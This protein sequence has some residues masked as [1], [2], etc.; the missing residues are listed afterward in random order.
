MSIGQTESLFEAAFALKAEAL[1]E[2]DRM[3]QPLPNHQL[4]TF[5]LRRERRGG[6]R[7]K[8]KKIA[9]DTA[10]LKLRIDGDRQ[11]PE[12]VLKLRGWH[13]ISLDHGD[14]PL[15]FPC[16]QCN[17]SAKRVSQSRFCPDKIHLVGKASKAT[18]G[19]AHENE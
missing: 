2:P 10:A 8:F 5:N 3:G 16:A 17:T 14:Q 7:T 11:L 15:A 18:R 13:P 9:S 19:P 12:N 6:C 4:D 1:I